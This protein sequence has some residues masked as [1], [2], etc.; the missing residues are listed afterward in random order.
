[1]GDLDYFLL[2][3]GGMAG[4]SCMTITASSLLYNPYIND[5]RP[6]T[7]NDTFMCYIFAH[8]VISR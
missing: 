8:V 3:I 4:L 5:I 7:D 6:D 1:M 2:V